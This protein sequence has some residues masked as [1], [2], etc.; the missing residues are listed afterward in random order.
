MT[1]RRSGLAVAFAVLAVTLVACTSSESQSA[2]PDETPAITATAEPSPS[3]SPSAT[4]EP[5]TSEEAE[6][7][8]AR[9]T[10]GTS[11]F[12]PTTLTVAAGTVVVFEN[13]ATFDHTVTEGTGGQ[14]VDD[15]IV[16]E[17]VAPGGDVRVTFDEPGTFDITCTIHPTMQMTIT[18][19]D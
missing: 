15:P 12:A 9:V 16:D 8:E 2:T 7:D 17:E 11:Q 19:E 18:V 13:E 6:A 5:S 3:T 14:A 10:I 4:A 1:P